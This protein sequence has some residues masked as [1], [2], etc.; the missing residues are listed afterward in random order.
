MKVSI[1][2]GCMDRKQNFVASAIVLMGGVFAAPVFGD[3][4]DATL[5][6]SQEN[7]YFSCPLDGGKIVSV[8]A[9]GNDKPSTGYVQYRYGTPEKVELIYP[10]KEVSPMGRFFVV[11]AS[12][13]SVNKDIIKF[14]NGKYTYIVAQASVSSL[15]VLKDDK[16]VLRKTC[17]EGGNAFV[18]RAARKGIDTVPKSAEDF[19]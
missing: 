18:S 15:T 16:V 17:G 11:N 4:V 1:F 19:R 9:S 6:T 10:R 13:G 12:E 8:C 2:G 14:K 7:I 3:E 5:C